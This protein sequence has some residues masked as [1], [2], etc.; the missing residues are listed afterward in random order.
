VQCFSHRSNL[1]EHF[2]EFGTPFCPQRANGSG[3]ERLGCTHIRLQ[4]AIHPYINP[5]FINMIVDK[6]SQM[7][8]TCGISQT[9]YPDT[10]FGCCYQHFQV[11]NYQVRHFK[12]HVIRQKSCGL[13][14]S[15]YPNTALT[16]EDIWMKQSQILAVN[17][18]LVCHKPQ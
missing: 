2:R 13:K 1:E 14:C 8:L 12:V 16:L 9:T 17:F 3:H 10:L 15:L 18:F 11:W 5:V 7:L 6:L 4:C